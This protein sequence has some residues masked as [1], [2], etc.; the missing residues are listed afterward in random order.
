MFLNAGILNEGCFECE[1]NQSKKRE[2]FEGKNPKGNEK[3]R[4]S[5]KA[6]QYTNSNWQK[7]R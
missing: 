6:N 1:H 4:A 2:L 7:L 3:N 5:N